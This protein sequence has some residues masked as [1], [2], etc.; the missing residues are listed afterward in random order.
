MFIEN[1]QRLA[2][3]S[4]AVFNLVKGQSLEILLV[5]KVEKSLICL[6]SNSIR[7]RTTANFVLENVN[8][9]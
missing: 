2:V 6:V 5:L 8:K 1:F 9:K 4:A 7:N 3:L